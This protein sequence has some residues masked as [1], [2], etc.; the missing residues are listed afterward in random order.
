MTYSYCTEMQGE[1]WDTLCLLSGEDVASIFI[2]YYGWQLVDEKFR[3][4]L[5]EEGYMEPYEG[6]DD[7]D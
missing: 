7:G 6:E 5:G 3:E 2:N 1:V 4:Y